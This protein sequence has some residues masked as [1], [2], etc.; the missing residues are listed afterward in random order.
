[1]RSRRRTRWAARLAIAACLSVTAGIAGLIVVNQNV[2]TLSD[3]IWLKGGNQQVSAN[4]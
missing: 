2:H 4:K 1:M 3:V